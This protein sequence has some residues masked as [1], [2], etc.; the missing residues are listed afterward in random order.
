MELMC[1][2]HPATYLI[3]FG[4]V[5]LMSDNHPALHL[6]NPVLPKPLEVDYHFIKDK[7]FSGIIITDIFTKS[8]GF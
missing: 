8:F 6:S 3:I 4:H 5:E 2:N 1:D 7:V